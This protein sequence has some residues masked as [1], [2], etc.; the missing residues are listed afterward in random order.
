MVCLVYFFILR[1]KTESIHP[2]KVETATKMQT[3]IKNWNISTEKW[4][5]HYV[6][7]KLAPVGK[8][9]G[10]LEQIM[11]GM[12]NASWHG[13]DFG[14]Y[15]SF[16]L[17]AMMTVTMRIMEKSIIPAYLPFLLTEKMIPCLLLKLV[18]FLILHVAIGFFFMPFLL[19]S[20]S[21]CIVYLG[22]IRMIPCLIV[23]FAFLCCLFVLK[24]EKLKKQQ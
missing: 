16:L 23:F 21:D 19:K 18:N 8:K 9:A 22:G 4:L 17:S 20:W 10:T 2:W 15:V 1:N 5:F 14:Y 11:T 6:Y 12:I 13:I 3:I 24:V 7:I